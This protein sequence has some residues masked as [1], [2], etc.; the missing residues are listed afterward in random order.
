M[1]PHFIFVILLVFFRAV[2]H[3][4]FSQQSYQQLTLTPQHVPRQIH[5]HLFKPVLLDFSSSF[6]KVHHLE[7]YPT[8]P[9]PSLLTKISRHVL[10][11]HFCSISDNHSFSAV[12]TASILVQA[13]IV[14]HLCP[15]NYLSPI[16]L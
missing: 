12:L 6:W 4:C 1:N 13:H 9:S 5:H 15:W 2:S 14:S 16:S 3:S 11:F 7:L 10:L 8:R